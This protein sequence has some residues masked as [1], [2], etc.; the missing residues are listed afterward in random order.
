MIGITSYG[1]HIP[2][3]RLTREEIARAHGGRKMPGEKAVCGFDEDSLTMAV[4]AATDCLGDFDRKAVDG[5]L[6]ATTTS[7]YV[8]KMVSTTAATA[9]DLRQNIGT[10]DFTNSLRAG[11]GALLSALNAVKA[12]SMKN[13]LVAAAD[14]RLTET[15]SDLEPVL[16][17]GAA[18]LML[19]DSNAAAVIEDSYSISD[20][21]I[22][23]WRSYGD[24]FIRIWED[25]FSID[26]GYSRVLPQ[27]VST[28]LGKHKLTPG[29]LAKAVFYAPNERRLRDMGKKLGLKPEQCQDELLGNVGNT[30]TAL[31]LMMLVAA[32]EEAKPDDRILLVGYGNGCDALLLRI[33]KDIEKIRGKRGI[34]GSLSSRKALLSYQKYMQWRELVSVAPAPRPE[35]LRTPVPE[36]WRD[37]RQNLALCGAM[38]KRCGT[39]QYPVQRVCVGCHAKD[40]FELVRLSDKRAKIFT[41]THDNLSPSVDPPASVAIVEFD[42][43]GRWTFDVTDRDPQEL[44]VG[45][46]VE[47]TFRKLNSAY[48]IHNYWWKVRPVGTPA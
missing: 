42:G 30:G 13:V 37:K 10:L 3:H 33:T 4:A 23:L 28:L 34:R 14:C 17:D 1:A 31:P 29:D 36:M 7:P 40:E 16:G 9:L 27:A 26:E 15:K 47:F 20:E 8:E 41:F 43:G 39:Q 12:G 24:K 35:R 2:M 22:D 21:F 38:C 18:A 46:E 19:G 5:F 32:L 44:Q 25:R 45:M 11:T 48:G 6:L